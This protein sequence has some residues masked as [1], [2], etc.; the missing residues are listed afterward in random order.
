MDFF[1]ALLSFLNKL[2]LPKYYKRDLE[3]LSYFDK[4]IIGYKIW[5]VK[6][7]LP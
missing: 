2:L 1:Y 6:K 3:K 4:A 7:R 5:L